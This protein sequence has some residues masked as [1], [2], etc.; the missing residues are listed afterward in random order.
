MP[1]KTAISLY[2]TDET[3]CDRMSSLL[4]QLADFEEHDQDQANNLRHLAQIIAKIKSR[5][6]HNGQPDQEPN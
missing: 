2:K 3:T 4:N 6:S 1:K 5:Y